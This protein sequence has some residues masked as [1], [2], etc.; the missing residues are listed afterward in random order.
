MTD[1]AHTTEK[2]LF[3]TTNLDANHTTFTKGISTW[4][5]DTKAK[6]KTIKLED[7]LRDNVGDCRSEDGIS[8]SK[9]V[10]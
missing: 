7:N 6:R 4:V 5:T 2:Q 8:S 9:N 1:A 3:K 10:P